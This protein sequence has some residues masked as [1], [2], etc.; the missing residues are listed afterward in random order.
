MADNMLDREIGALQATVSMLATALKDQGVSHDR[1]LREYHA[2]HKEAIKKF[3]G[4]VDGL[5]LQI[6]S[7]KTDH[8]EMRSL[9]DQA[10]GG[11]KILIGAVTISAA[12]T[13]AISKLGS[14]FWITIR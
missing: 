3:E 10:K 7:L 6:A 13:A 5:T 8:G 2:Q 4:L 1:M 14:Y 12:L 11:W 9:V